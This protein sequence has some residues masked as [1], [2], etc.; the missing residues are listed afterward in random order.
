MSGLGISRGI[1]GTALAA[2][3]LTMPMVSAPH[4][5]A[6]TAPTMAVSLTGSALGAAR[7]AA[8][9]C[10]HTATA[11]VKMPDG[12]PVST[13]FVDFTSRLPGMPGNIVGT[14]PVTNGTASIPW[15]PDIDGQHVIS[16]VYFD[17]PAELRPAASY[18]TVTA[19]NTGGLCA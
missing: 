14:V 8:V 2:A 16:A 1:A 6:A 15:T 5:L 3:A 13:G 11:T 4:A 9:N 10:T 19:M 12:S 17:G 18:T 7:L